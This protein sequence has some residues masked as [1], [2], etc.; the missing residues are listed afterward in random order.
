MS[1]NKLALN[2]RYKLV[3]ER[4]LRDTLRYRRKI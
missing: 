4:Y 1:N 3:Q 2:Y